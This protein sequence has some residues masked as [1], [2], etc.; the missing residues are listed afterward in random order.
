M[1]GDV[2]R[3]SQ[4]ASRAL[5]SREWRNSFPEREAVQGRCRAKRGGG[6]VQ[7][8]KA[9]FAP[10]DA[11]S[12]REAAPAVSGQPLRLARSAREP[13]PPD[14]CAVPGRSFVR[15][16]NT[17][18]DSDR[19]RLLR[20]TPIYRGRCRA[21]RG[22]GAVRRRKVLLTH[23]PHERSASSTARFLGSGVIDDSADLLACLTLRRRHKPE[24]GPE[25]EREK[26]ASDQ[27]D[28]P[29]TAGRV[30]SRTEHRAGDQER[31]RDPRERRWRRTSLVTPARVDGLVA[32]HRLR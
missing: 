19:L 7:P 29:N 30:R 12:S 20:R 10:R 18:D 22:G 28:P 8:R 9:L 15:R 6:A 24:A 23:V 31:S 11:R 13:P 2:S 17:L 21:R 25:A 1:P 32:V 5:G 27:N 3:S 26:D 16:A 4:S 14:C